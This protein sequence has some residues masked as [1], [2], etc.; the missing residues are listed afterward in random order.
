MGRSRAR[1]WAPALVAAV[2]LSAVAPAVQA[3]TL[4]LRRAHA[5]TLFFV[6]GIAFAFNVAA[7]PTVRCFRDGGGAHSVYCDWRFRRINLA[8][9]RTDLCGGRIRVYFSGPSVRVHRSIVRP[10]RCVAL[11]R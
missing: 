1:S 11:T 10:R 4:T 7:D 2:V 9:G 6:R 5:D 3:H 8:T